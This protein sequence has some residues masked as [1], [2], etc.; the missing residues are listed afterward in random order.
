MR[1]AAR[2]G[3]AVNGLLNVMIGVLAL[4]V[5]GSAAGGSA[6]PNGALTGLA[7]APGG[8]LLI[9]VI[10]VGM[11]A[12]AIWQLAT[13]V[14]ERDVDR[15]RRWAARAKSVGKGVAYLALA[16][17]GIRVTLNASGGGAEEDLTAAA[18]ST[19]GG[20]VLVVLAGLVALG[21]GG[22]MIVKGVRQKFLD[23]VTL[24]AGAVK[25]VTTV[26]GI[27][28]YVARGVAIAAIGFLFLAAAVTSDASQAGGLD[29]ALAAL[30]ALPLGKVLLVAIALGFIA[31]GV[32]GSAR[33]R[34]AKL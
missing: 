21:V 23:D 31:Y 17:I 14:Q 32:Y 9:W 16:V 19:P 4:G 10:V 11:L 13:A 26:L 22:Y 5:V 3:F 27:V 34:F 1:T 15:K 24:P 30:A 20:V 8:Q 28:G 7:Q 25:K 6:D 33:A 18:L 2:L 12:L 29:D